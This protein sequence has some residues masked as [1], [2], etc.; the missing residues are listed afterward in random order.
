MMGKKSSGKMSVKE[1]ARRREQAKTHALNDTTKQT[2]QKG[3]SG[4][5]PPPPGGRQFRHQ[6][7]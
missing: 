7:R 6:G 4:G 3:K 5:K 2:G 1:M